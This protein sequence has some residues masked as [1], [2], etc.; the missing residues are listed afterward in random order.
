MKLVKGDS[1]EQQIQHIDT[2]LQR[3][4]RRTHKTVVGIIPPNLTFG[5][6]DKPTEDGILLRAIFPAGRLLKG[7]M[8]VEH[9]A[10]KQPVTFVAEVSGQSGSQTRDFT[11]RKQLLVIE[12]DL[13]LDIGDRLT[14]KVKEWDK[15]QGIWIGFLFHIEMKDSV[16]ETYL[17]DQIDALNAELV[18]N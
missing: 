16:K 8:Y 18:E 15:V 6:V 11:T 3:M 4:Q 13:Q 9:Y 2:V 1:V 17:L 12:P 14:F 10:D 7:F 5:F